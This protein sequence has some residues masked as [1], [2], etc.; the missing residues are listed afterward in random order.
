MFLVLSAWVSLLSAAQNNPYKINDA[1]YPIYQRAAKQ[2]RQQEGLLVADTLY[3]QALKL[4][5]QKKHNAWHTL[6]PCSSI[7]LKKTIAK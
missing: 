7:C 1:L 6:S 4:G 3:Q 5:D 2:A